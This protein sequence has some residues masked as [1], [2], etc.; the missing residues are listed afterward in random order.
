V[1]ARSLR[2]PVAGR[3][4]AGLVAISLAVPMCRLVGLTDD[5]RIARKIGVVVGATDV[6]GVLRVVRAETP[7]DQRK[8]ALGNVCLDLALAT[9]LLF[10]GFRRRGAERLASFVAA[11][12]VY[13][14]AG[15]W[16][17]GASHM[18]D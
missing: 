12:S 3:S 6:A 14:G 8:A 15:A 9:A 2:M 5:P 11:A 1:I 18:T 10:L 16:S 7:D 4:I 13:F 17:V